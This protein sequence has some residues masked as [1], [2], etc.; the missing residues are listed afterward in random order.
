M[1]PTTTLRRVPALLDDCIVARPLTLRR[2]GSVTYFSTTSYRYAPPTAGKKKGTGG[3][4]EGP[5]KGRQTLKIKRDMRVKDA[6]IGTPESRKAFRTRIIL[7]NTNA[8]TVPGLDRLTAET[9]F[10]KESIGKVFTI[11]GNHIDALRLMGA[12]KRTQGWHNY[13]GPA[14]LIRQ[15]TWYIGQRM[16]EISEAGLGAETTRKVII[17]ERKSGKSVLILQALSMAMLR[18]WVVINIP[19]CRELTDALTS[20]Y[21]P[22]KGT[23]PLQFYQKQYS[24]T[25]LDQIARVNRTVLSKIKVSQSHTLPIRNLGQM[26]L[27]QLAEHGAA[28]LDLAWPVFQALWT[29]LTAKND[30][31]VVEKFGKRP[32]VMF[33]ADNISYIFGESKYEKLAENDKLVPVHTFDL[34]LPKHYIDLLTGTTTLP[35]GGIILGA[36]SS[37][38]YITCPPLDVAIE[39]GQERLQYPDEKLEVNDFWNPLVKIDRRVLDQ[40]I[41]IDVLPLK[42]ISKEEAREIIGYWALSG[43]VRDRVQDNYVGEKWTMSGGGVIGELEKAVVRMNLNGGT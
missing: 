16:N 14:T 6:T 23:D 17:G 2:P 21:N 31:E 33:C 26:N 39:M 38:H 24:A 11:P 13:K 22:V 15:E 36:T 35:N 28:E 25:L 29:E 19:E 27:H 43:L 40:V 3:H 12:F 34:L 1:R 4:G 10:A 20:D 8:N 30:P 9:A 7:E 18:E 5:K 41:N 37:S 42:G 32:P